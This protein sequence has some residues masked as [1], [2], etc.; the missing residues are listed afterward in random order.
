M[1]AEF[2]YETPLLIGCEWPYSEAMELERVKINLSSTKSPTTCR[3]SAQNISLSPCLF[4]FLMHHLA[5]GFRPGPEPMTSAVETWKRRF[6]TTTLPGKGQPQSFYYQ[7]WSTPYTS[8][9]HCEI[10]TWRNSGDF[11]GGPVVKTLHPQC[12]GCRFDPLSGT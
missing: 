5:R 4:F 3:L 8:Q 7:L 2:N 10:Y 12:R 6:L 11:P 1:L 9:S